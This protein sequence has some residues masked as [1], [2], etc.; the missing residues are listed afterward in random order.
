[1]HY[2]CANTAAYINTCTFSQIGC[3]GTLFL[4]YMQIKREKN[5]KKLICIDDLTMDEGVEG[6]RAAGTERT[7]IYGHEGNVLGV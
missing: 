2:R 6:I 5:E 1:M 7:G 4:A 3:K